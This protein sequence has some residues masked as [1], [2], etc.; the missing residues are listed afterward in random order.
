MSERKKV[1]GLYMWGSNEW[2]MDNPRRMRFDTPEATFDFL[3]DYVKEHNTDGFTTAVRPFYVTAR[4]IPADVQE[5]V[6]AAQKWFVHDKPEDFGSDEAR[7]FVRAV[8][9]LDG[10]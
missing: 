10:K 2:W 8:R 4:P 6:E 5:L 9:A 3:R 1:W 7:R